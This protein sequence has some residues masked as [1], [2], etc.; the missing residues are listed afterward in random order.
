MV[1]EISLIS[2]PFSANFSKHQLFDFTIER[3][4]IQ[5]LEDLISEAGYYFHIFPLRQNGKEK[6]TYIQQ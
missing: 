3:R 2:E 4:H 6:Y 5:K 1:V